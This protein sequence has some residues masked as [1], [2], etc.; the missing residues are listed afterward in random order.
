[1]TDGR[2]VIWLRAALIAVVPAALPATPA[3]AAQLGHTVDPFEGQPVLLQK[4]LE[5]RAPAGGGPDLTAPRIVLTDSTDIYVFDP[6][7]FGIHRFDRDGRWVATIGQ[8]GEGP[9]EFRRPTAMGWSSDT[10]WVADRGLSRLSY[11]DRNGA[12]LRSVRFSIVEG[13]ATFMPNRA[14]EGRRIVSV[15]YVPVRFSNRL[16]SL[17]VLLFDEDGT[18]RDT[19]AWRA[20]GQA[21]VSITT[22]SSDTPSGVRI[23]SISHPFDRRSLAAYDPKGR[24]FFAG[25]WRADGHGGEH[26]ELLKVTVAGDTAAKVSLPLKRTLLSATEVRSYVRQIYG[27]FS[28][29]FRSRVTSRELADEFLQQI[30]RPSETAVDAMVA[31]ETGE[32]WL[33]RTNREPERVPT[34]WI[35]YRPTKGF[36]GIVEFPVGVHLLNV[37]DGILWTVRHDGLGLPILTGWTEVEPEDAR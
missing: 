18:V 32:V 25:T 1:M 16:D 11:F 12:F 3:V 8:E 22:Q 15:P 28:E 27:G 17:P 7:A 35:Q 4:R 29:S 31:G 13:A 33:R 9:G 37:T 34:R 21:T 14:L 24:W 36:G 23:M 20:L 30:S 6:A 2:M 10:L 5:V 26:L 19:L